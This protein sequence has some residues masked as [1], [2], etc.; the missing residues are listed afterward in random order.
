[1]V[2]AISLGAL[3]SM[4]GCGCPSRSSTSDPSV[5]QLGTTGLPHQSRRWLSCTSQ[6]TVGLSGSPV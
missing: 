2:T 5:Y 3:R 4:T 6:V 1:M